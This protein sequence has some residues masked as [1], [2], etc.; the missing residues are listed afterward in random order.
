[1]RLSSGWRRLVLGAAVVAVATVTATAFVV[2]YPSVV[3]YPEKWRGALHE[4][5]TAQVTYDANTSTSTHFDVEARYYNCHGSPY[6][7]NRIETSGPL[8]IGTCDT[9]FAPTF[10]PTPAVN[11][12]LHVT[13]TVDASTGRGKHEGTMELVYFDEAHQNGFVFFKGKMV[14]VD[15]FTQ[16]DDTSTDADRCDDYS[17]SRGVCEGKLKGSALLKVSGQTSE[18]IRNCPIRFLY[19]IRWGVVSNPVDIVSLK[20]MFDGPAFCVCPKSAVTL[21]E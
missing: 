12:R 9:L 6:W 17:V 3:T 16:V 10:G 11:M 2:V 15:G 18:A 19:R 4:M 20:A 5:E 1:M 13:R 7:T 14:G 21:A 8:A